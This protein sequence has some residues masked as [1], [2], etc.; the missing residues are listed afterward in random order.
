MQTVEGMLGHEE[1]FDHRRD[2][3][4]ELLPLALQARHEDLRE[5]R[6]RLRQLR[7]VIRAI[8]NSDYV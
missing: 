8:A 1:T 3:L 5:S 7:L 2:A 6:L 4:P